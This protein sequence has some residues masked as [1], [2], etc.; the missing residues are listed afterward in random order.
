VNSLM[1]YLSQSFKKSNSYSSSKV[2][3]PNPGPVNWYP[4]HISRVKSKQFFGQTSRLRPENQAISGPERK[5]IIEHGSVG[6][7]VNQARMPYIH[8]SSV[9]IWIELHTDIR[10]VIEARS[11]ELLVRNSK[12]KRPYQVQR[13]VGR[14][15]GPCNIPGV[16]RYFRL[17]KKH[18]EPFARPRNIATGYII[19]ILVRIEGVENQSP[20]RLRTA[21]TKRLA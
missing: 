10:P 3:T 18:A 1:T 19:G 21:R 20:F 12:T 4:Y 13:R 9:E 15:A 11:F 2:Q 6:R 14:G 7:K 8:M 17:V 5:I 16:L